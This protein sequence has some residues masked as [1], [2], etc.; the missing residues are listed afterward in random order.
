AMPMSAHDTASLIAERLRAAKSI[1]V[2]AHVTPDA[3]AL[4]S[5]LALGMALTSLQLDQ[6]VVVSFGDEPMQVPR[7]LATLPGQE[8][9]AEP[10][11]IASRDGA[12]DVSISC[13]VSTIDRLGANHA[14][15]SAAA[16]TIVIDHHVSNIGFGDINFIDP[17]AAANVV[18]T[19]RV[20]DALGAELTAPVAHALY[21]GLITDTGNFKFSATNTDAH[22]MAARLLETGLRHDVVARQMYDDEPFACLQLLGQCLSRAVLDSTALQGA[23][24]VWTTVTAADREALGLS[25]DAGE[26]VIDTIRIASE[27]EVACVFKEDDTGVWKVSLRSKGAVDVGAVAAVLGGG[28]HKFAAGATLGDDVALALQDVRRALDAVR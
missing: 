3:D 12:F 15:F 13:D 5:A 26:R 11:T 14:A 18:L 8:L 19:L 25:L 10:A 6:D 21:A 4:G 1:L 20:I 22:V 23:G 28:G 7:T 17:S 16:T 9:L 27:A 24:F 2:L